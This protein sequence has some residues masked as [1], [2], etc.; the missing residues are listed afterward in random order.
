MWQALNCRSIGAITTFAFACAHE[1][2]PG[3]DSHEAWVGNVSFYEDTQMD[4]HNNAVGIAIGS[5]VGDDVSN[6][7]LAALVFDI[8]VN[9]GEG[10]VCF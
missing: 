8:I 5:V 2:K 1:N 3:N 10:V 9:S 4:L 7:D 6:D